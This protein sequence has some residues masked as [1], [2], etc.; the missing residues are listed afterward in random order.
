[1]NVLNDSSSNE[2]SGISS[3]GIDFDLS[4]YDAHLD[5]VSSKT[6]KIA[7]Q[8]KKSFTKL[9]NS[10]KKV[11]D[12][13]PVQAYVNLITTKF[14]FTKDAI[15]QIGTDIYT[16]LNS[17]WNNIKDSAGLAFNNISTLFTNM[18]TDMSSG[19]DMWGQ[20]LIDGVSN[21][22]NS[23]WETA[24]NPA[25]ELISNRWADFSG[26]LVD[27]WNEHGQS[28]I[29]NLGEFVTNVIGLFK[30]IY[31]N[32]LEPIVTPL[33]EQLSWLWDEHISKTVKSIG[34]FIGKLINGAMELYNK[35]FSPIVN[36]LLDYLSPAWSQMTSLVVGVL[37]TLLGTISDIVSGIFELFGG[38]IDFITG[39]FTGDWKK[40]WNGV[41]SAFKG[42]F[43]SLIGIF[44][45]PIN[46]IIDGMNSF[47]SGLNKIKIP[48]WVPAVGGKGID[49]PKIPKLAQ[50]GV[51][52]K[53]TYAMIGEA[54]TEAVMPLER[55]TG[56]IDKL[57]DKLGSK[58][59]SSED[60]PIQLTVKIGEDTIMDK[61]IKG[62]KDKEFEM[63]G[64]IY[65]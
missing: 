18:W 26:I 63:N 28:L 60:T 9:G 35:F 41:K 20:P 56:W 44:K 5:W 62:I 39:V 19:I 52:D 17:T 11:W 34:D 32:V 16:N 6:D 43:D 55:N 36:F 31:D 58:I 59:G 38:V 51:V 2:S 3:G 37:G 54:G 27:L 22:F 29:D 65:V 8:I 4:E 57:A 1:M 40:A 49:I 30:S 24:I 25:I 7:E 15:M 47:I 13:K 48:D 14:N 50:G 64:V 61:V 53:P 23:I 12:S 10:L 21:L 46:L 33:L 42:V 45:T